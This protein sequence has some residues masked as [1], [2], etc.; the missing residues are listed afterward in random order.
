MYALCG[1]YTTVMLS[2]V[3]TRQRKCV[4]SSLNWGRTCIAM[5]MN[6]ISSVLPGYK[7]AFSHDQTSGLVLIITVWFVRYFSVKESPILFHRHSNA[8]VVLLHWS[9]I[10]ESEG[11]VLQQEQSVIN[12]YPESRVILP[13]FV[14]IKKS[15]LSREHTLHKIW[16]SDRGIHEASSLLE[17]YTMS[18]GKELPTFWRRVVHSAGVR[19]S[20]HHFKII[21]AWRVIWSKF[22][23]KDPQIL[24]TTTQNP[25]AQD[26]C[27]P[28]LAY[29]VKESSSWAAWPC[30]WRYYAPPRHQ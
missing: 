9:A 15:K 25:V 8:N 22:H 14:F 17:C 21:S 3:Y 23:I 28:G 5:N 4:D 27:T 16:G 10:R 20:R 30:I 11:T 1:Q 2:Y 6:R 13:F 24:G 19:K 29:R 7:V 18:I 26:L 12:M